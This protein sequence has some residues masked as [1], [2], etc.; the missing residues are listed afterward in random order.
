VQHLEFTSSVAEDRSSDMQCCITGQ[1]VPIVSKDYIPPP[2]LFK[3]NT[4]IDLCVLVY[5][6][7]TDHGNI[8]THLPND[9]VSHPRR[10]K[11]SILVVAFDD[12]GEELKGISES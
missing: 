5:E 9:T 6:G 10:C 1:V 11:S 12:M 3:G 2:P 4:V 8:R 7:T